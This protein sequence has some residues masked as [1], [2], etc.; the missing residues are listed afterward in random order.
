MKEERGGNWKSREEE[1]KG[2]RKRGE[3]KARK[4]REEE[5]GG[6]SHIAG[7]Q[8]KNFVAPRSTSSHDKTFRRQKSSK[9][10]CLSQKFKISFKIFKEEH[11]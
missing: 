5:R 8:R 4:R 1:R 9:I 2:K 3:K 6:K 10:M 7:L 11:P